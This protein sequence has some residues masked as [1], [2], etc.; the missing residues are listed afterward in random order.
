MYERAQ[1]SQ[2]VSFN[3]HPDEFQMYNLCNITGSALV[4]TFYAVAVGIAAGVGFATQT[5]L[6][7]SYR[8]LM[9]YFGAL[10]VLCTVP[11]FI[12]NKHRPGQQLPQ[13]TKIWVAGPK[14]VIL[15]LVHLD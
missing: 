11:F 15:L 6:I 2:I 14:S 4:V 13:G 10:T 7:T 8:V 3:V 1:V 9:G 12:V 5:Q